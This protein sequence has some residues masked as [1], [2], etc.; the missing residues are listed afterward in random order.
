MKTL[1]CRWQQNRILAVL[2]NPPSKTPRQGAGVLSQQKAAK[3]IIECYRVLQKT[4]GN[5]VNEI[6]R[7]ADDFYEWNHYPKGNVLDSDSRAQYYYH[8]HP[9][10]LRGT[11]AEHGHFHC[12]LYKDGMP[13]ACNALVL[14]KSDD[15]NK[16]DLCHLMSISM[17]AYGFPIA[18]FTTNRW[19]TGEAWYKATDVISMLEHFNIDHAQPSWPLNIWITN[20][21]RLFKPAMVKLIL[22]RDKSIQDWQATHPDQDALEDRE[23]EVT[24]YQAISVEETIK[25]LP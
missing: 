22:Q 23:L 8:T 4:G 2:S 6:L 20:M 11:P 1:A 14:P 10:A 24:S 16:A 25:V 12:F 18:L 3:H 15:D 7:Q 21:F 19:V 9:P 5:I 17:D 13:S